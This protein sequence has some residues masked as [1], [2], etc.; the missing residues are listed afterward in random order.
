LEGK[1]AGPAFGSQPK[2]AN[3]RRPTGSAP[4]SSSDQTILTIRTPLP[5]NSQT[6]RLGAMLRD[7][8]G[9][10]AMGTNDGGS[11]MTAVR[12]DLPA[13]AQLIVESSAGPVIRAQIQIIQPDV[14]KRSV[15]RP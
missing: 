3:A 1:H 5:A 11:M 10:G 8:A 2:L 14:P 12:P 4:G 15:T 9:C 7:A 13:D 6:P